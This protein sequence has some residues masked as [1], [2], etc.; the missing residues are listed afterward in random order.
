MTCLSHHL[1]EFVAKSAEQQKEQEALVA[2]EKAAREQKVP[3]L[4]SRETANSF[5]SVPC[6]KERNG[7]NLQR[8]RQNVSKGYVCVPAAQR[9]FW[10][11]SQ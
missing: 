5:Y 3:E 9:T 6:R 2:K 4:F 8:R 10:F 7:R 11:F 1:S